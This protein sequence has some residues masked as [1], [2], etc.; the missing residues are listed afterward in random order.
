MSE[1]NFFTTMSNFTFQSTTG[2]INSLWNYAYAVIRVANAVLKHLPEYFGEAYTVNDDECEARFHRAYAYS[3]LLNYF[4]GVPITTNFALSNSNFNGTQPIEG[5]RA[6]REEVEN[7]IYQDCDIV[8]NLTD[9]RKDQ[10][11]QLKARVLMN[12]GK[13]AEASALLQEIINSGGY[14]LSSYEE[15][16]GPQINNVNLPANMIKFPANVVHPMRY[17]E[18]LLLNA[19]ALLNLGR[20]ADA[21]QIINMFATYEGRELP[22]D[23][24]EAITYLRTPFI[25]W[26]GSVV[27]WASSRIDKEGLTFAYAKRADFS[28]IEGMKAGIEYPSLLHE[29]WNNRHKLLPIPQSAI[30]ANP[31]I[32]QNPGW[33]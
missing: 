18:T 12:S 13:Y 26:D 4:G 24:R 19:E 5:S 11:R 7:L 27:P 10:V 9:S 1:F 33:N 28:V 2:E 14:T 30:D 16:L 6:T 25:S 21:L 23:I 31:E 8:S 32:T 15:P 20:N 22:D 29:F 3:I 17:A